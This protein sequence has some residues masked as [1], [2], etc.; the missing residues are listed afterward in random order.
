VRDYAI[1][2]VFFYLAAL[3]LIDLLDWEGLSIKQYL[4]RNK[5]R[6]GATL[7]ILIYAVIDA[8]SV[9]KIVV[10]VYAI[11]GGL[12]ILKI[13]KTKPSLWFKIAAICTG[14]A[15]IVFVAV[16]SGLLVRFFVR[17]TFEYQ[18]DLTSWNSMVSNNVRQWYV[19][20]GISYLF[21]VIGGFFVLRSIFA[22]YRKSDFVFLLCYTACAAILFYLVFFLV[23][24]HVPT[25]ARY[26]ILVEYWY[27]IVVATALYVGFYAFQRKFGNRF[28]AVPIVIIAALFLNY[29]SYITIFTYHG[30]GVY[31]L[32]G[33]RHYIVEPAYDYLTE[34]LTDKD[35]LMTDVM[36][37]Y[38]MISGHKFGDIKIISFYSD[39]PLNVIKEYPQGYIAVTAA[40]H[41]EKTNL[42]FADFDYAGKY[43]HYLGLVGEVNL[44][45]WASA[46]SH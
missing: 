21:I 17:G 43:I 7:L 36:A 31:Q 37:Y 23:N 1:V 4:N 27:L 9:L 15:S 33:E 12:A 6:I 30:G 8:L 16:Y 44:W 28:L 42:Q 3:L 41:P 39:D 34:H 11:F 20:G 22:R 24:P 35:V 2:P 32:T 5:Y 25:R 14:V 26:G 10:V 13:W 38:D 40:F 18:I 29:Q 45:Q 46:S 19:F